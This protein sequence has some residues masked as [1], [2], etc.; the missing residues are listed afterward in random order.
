MQTWQSESS[1]STI[2]PK[3]KEGETLKAAGTEDTATVTQ[4]KKL[5]TE[6]HTRS[7]GGQ[8]RGRYFQ[9][10]GGI[11]SEGTFSKEEYEPSTTDL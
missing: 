9:S 10:V 5:M 3:L 1:P 6:F 2:Q 8:R 11:F 7:P 4:G